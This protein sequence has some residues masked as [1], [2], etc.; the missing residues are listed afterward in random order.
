MP[1]IPEVP[2]ELAAI[3][4]RAVGRE[5]SATGPVAAHRGVTMTGAE[6]REAIARIPDEAYD[7][8]C[9]HDLHMVKT[10]PYLQNWSRVGDLQLARLL[11][12]LAIQGVIT[13]NPTSGTPDQ[14]NGAS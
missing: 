6:I 11:Y 1:E 12:G 14:P 5:H 8:A 7:A 4:D 3:L 9:E 13:I 2:P 10:S